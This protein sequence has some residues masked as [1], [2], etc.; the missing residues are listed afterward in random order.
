MKFQGGKALIGKEIAEYI[1]HD[2]AYQM[3]FSP[4]C[5]ALGVERHLVKDFAICFFSDISKDLIMFLKELTSNSFIF[6]FQVTEENY[7]KLK[8]DEPSALR[9]FV[10]YFLSFAGKWFGGYAPKYQKGDRVRDFLKEATD[11]SKRLRNDLKN[12]DIIFDSKSYDEYTPFKMT[13]YCDPPYRNTTG[14]GTNLDYDKFWNIMNQ[15]SQL[16]E[17][18]VSSYEAPDEWECV[19]E[20]Q[21]RMTLGTDKTQTRTEKLFKLKSQFINDIETDLMPFSSK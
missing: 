12:G 9:G 7:K 14:Y 19:W 4:F 8:Y 13:I 10:G 3:L 18:Y 1:R 2:K 15:W 11:S 20:Q 6:P 5:G 17:V 21:K 16:N